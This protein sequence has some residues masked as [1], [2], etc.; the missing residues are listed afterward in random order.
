MKLFK[1]IASRRGRVVFDDRIEAVTPRE[2]RNQMRA[3]LGLRSLTGVVYSITE[4]PV[5]LIAEIAEAR[6]T[7]AL[8]RYEEGAT[9]PAVDEAIRAAA[10]EEVRRQFADWR[11]EVRAEAP[12]DDP[13]PERRP[14]RFD[15]FCGSDPD[16]AAED[17]AAPAAGDLERVRER[18]RRQLSGIREQMSNGSSPRAPVVERVQAHAEERRR[19]QRQQP[20]RASVTTDGRV[21]DWPAVRRLYRRNR[22]LKQTAAAF[23]LSV[24]TV[25]ARARKEGWA[26]S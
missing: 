15:P 10:A 11:D 25:K 22:S 1:V 23:D 7:E 16:A 24:N 20:G 8:R 21:I 3:L 14:E 17:A 13:A 26:R 18:A 19:R 4:I 2:A 5:E 6:V 9:P 12:R